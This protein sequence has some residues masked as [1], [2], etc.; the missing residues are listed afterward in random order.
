MIANA[1]NRPPCRTAS[2][3]VSANLL[4]SES[5]RR[6]TK[7]QIKV[8]KEATLIKEQ[9][10]AAKLAQYDVL[11]GKVQLM[12]EEKRNGDAAVSL[13]KQFIETGFARQDDEGA[14]IL[15]GLSGEKKFKP[16]E[17]G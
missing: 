15:P 11:K 9:Q 8:E 17:E 7:Q 10:D 6:R 14:F 5:K 12:E 16:F 1:R 3:G 2:K 4:Q 13:L